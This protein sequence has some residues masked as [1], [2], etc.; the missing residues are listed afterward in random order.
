MSVLPESS[1]LLTEREAREIT[2]KL[3]SYVKA[4]HAAVSHGCPVARFR[5]SMF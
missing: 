2:E 3:L 1:M 5:A 4:D